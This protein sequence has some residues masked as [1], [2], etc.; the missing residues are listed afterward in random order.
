MKVGEVA[1]EGV[2]EG[3]EEEEEAGEGLVVDLVSSQH[4]PKPFPPPFYLYLSV[5][6]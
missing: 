3:E 6:R 1:G 2:V 4:T 5:C